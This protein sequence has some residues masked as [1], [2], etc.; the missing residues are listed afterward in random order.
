VVANFIAP[1]RKNWARVSQQFRRRFTVSIFGLGQGAVLGRSVGHDQF[2]QTEEIAEL[3]I[4]P[5]GKGVVA[6]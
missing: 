4:A 3:M 5:I 1:F 6:T 2:L